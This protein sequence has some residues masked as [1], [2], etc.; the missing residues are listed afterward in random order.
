MSTEDH[1]HPAPHHPVKL[2]RIQFDFSDKI[3]A[4]LHTLQTRLKAAT[5]GEVILKALKVLIW[6]E[7]HLHHGHTIIVKK[8]NGEMVQAHFPFLHDTTRTPAPPDQPQGQSSTDQP[9]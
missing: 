2:H 8:K 7:E 9:S 5:R 6:L 1:P 3:L 4:H